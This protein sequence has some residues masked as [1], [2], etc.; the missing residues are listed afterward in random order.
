[1]LRAFD[2]GTRWRTFS[3]MS[4]VDRLGRPL[5]LAAAAA[6]LSRAQPLAGLAPF[7]LA[8]LAAGLAV[9]A[10]PLALLLG[11]LAGA[12]GAEGFQWAAPAGACVVLGGA[13]AARLARGW[14]QR[15]AVRASPSGRVLGDAA[16]SALAG[17]GVLAPGAW[18]AA[19]GAW[20]SV[21]MIGSAVMAAASAPFFAALM[22]VKP[23]RRHL[24]PEERAGLAIFLLSGLAGLAALWPPAALTAGFAGALAAAPLGAGAGACAGLAA[25]GALMLAGCDPGRALALGACGMLAALAHSRR[26]WT[27]ALAMAAAGAV[28]SLALCAPAAEALCAPVAALAVLAVPERHLARARGWLVGEA[29]G[30]C[31]PDRLAARL[32]AESGRKLRAMSDAFGELSDGYRIPVDIPD[33]QSLIADMRAR[34]CDGCSNYPTCWAGDDNRAVR[35]LC[36]LVSEAIDWAAGDCALPLFGEEI[37]PELTRQCRRARSIPARLGEPLEEFARKRRSEMKR[38]AVNQ[39]ISAQFMQAQMLLRGL[40]DAQA[41]PLRVRGRQAARARAALDRAGI[42]TSDVMALRGARRMEL[43]AALK[44]GRW[45]PELAAQASAQLSRVFGRAYAPAGSSG[46]EMRFIRLSRLRATAAVSCHSRQAG[47]PCGDSHS[48]RMLEGDRLLMMLSD[49]MGSGADA[50]RESAQ[51]LRL[52]GRFLEADVSRELALETVNELMLA[53]SDSDMFATVDMCLIDLATGMAEFT[54]L[55]ACRSLIL[56]KG[57]V[58][59]VEGGKLPLGILERVQPTVYAIR[60]EPGDVVVMASDGVMDAVAPEVLSE[61]LIAHGRQPPAMLAET[62]L[63]AVERRLDPHR[64]DDMTAMCARIALRREAG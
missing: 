14:V 35:F 9:G 42:E 23:S 18:L 8:L 5:A 22:E 49:G 6:L 53:R 21:R 13:A 37:P 43:V 60:L 38:S 52:L 47:V 45:T 54:K 2:L 20:E 46:A 24:M 11:S 28:S 61:C 40:A 17:L 57:E 7:A 64:R 33:E 62:I 59:A 32:R 16:V 30:A 36:Q 3:S 34:L 50:A 44:Q 55:A 39:L 63:S 26:R 19:G 56:R 51:T 1:M 48:I 15:R 12:F 27:S 58:I 41:R 31:D 29:R 25:A 10:H 4:W